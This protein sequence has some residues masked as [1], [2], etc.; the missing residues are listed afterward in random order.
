[1]IRSFHNSAFRH[2]SGIV[3]LG[4]VFIQAD[5]ARAASCSSIQGHGSA[6]S[7]AVATSR[8]QSVVNRQR[9]RLGRGGVF[10]RQV[11]CVEGRY[12]Y[13]RTYSCVVRVRF[14][15]LATVRPGSKIFR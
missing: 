9:A 8:A 5:A 3:I 14:C 11:R 6:F 12:R 4:S 2:L 7:Q 1:M 15:S 13:R 10:G